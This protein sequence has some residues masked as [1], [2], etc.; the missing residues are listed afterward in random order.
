[1]TFKGFNLPYFSLLC[2]IRYLDPIPGRFSQISPLHIYSRFISCFLSYTSDF[3]FIND[4]DNVQCEPYSL[5]ET[6]SALQG[7][8][9]MPAAPSVHS[10]SAPSHAQK[11]RGYPS[12][13]LFSIPWIFIQFQPGLLSCVHNGLHTILYN[14]GGCFR[15]PQN[16]R[17]T[18]LSTNNGN[19]SLYTYYANSW[20]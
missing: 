4:T 8:R 12:N 9:S 10:V 13:H 20:Y 14:F 17:N 15:C 19:C 5:P 18:I 6:Q 2:L 1:M 7:M 16:R 11:V 3:L